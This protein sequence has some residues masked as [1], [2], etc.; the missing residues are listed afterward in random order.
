M[1]VVAVLLI[2]MDKKAVTPMKPNIKLP[3]KWKKRKKIIAVVQQLAG[4][5]EK[6]AGHHDHIELYTEKYY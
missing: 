3:G 1:A 4:H 5:F 2:H 6:E